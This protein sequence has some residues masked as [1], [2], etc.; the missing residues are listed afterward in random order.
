ML[1]VINTLMLEACDVSLHH[2]HQIEVVVDATPTWVNLCLAL[3]NLA[4]CNRSL[5]LETVVLVLQLP[6]ES[7]SLWLHLL[8]SVA[9][10]AEAVLASLL[11]VA[12]EVSSVL[13]ARESEL[14]LPKCN[15]L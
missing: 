3:H 10:V 7:R 8:L 12:R 14:S 5:G 4:Q 11:R 1:K 15:L 13:V 2:L 9:E 6:S